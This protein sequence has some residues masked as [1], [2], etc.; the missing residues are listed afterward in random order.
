MQ[1]NSDMQFNSA[2]YFVIPGLSVDKKRDD[3]ESEMISLT[4][5]HGLILHPVIENGIATSTVTNGNSLIDLVY[6]SSSLTV[7]TGR[8]YELSL[9]DHFPISLC[10]KSRAPNFSITETLDA[11][12]FELKYFTVDPSKF[13]TF[14]FTQDLLDSASDTYSGSINEADNAILSNLLELANDRKPERS[15]ISKIDL[16]IAET[17]RQIRRAKNK[18]LKSGKFP[19]ENRV[20]QSFQQRLQKLIHEKDTLMKEKVRSKFNKARLDKNAKRTW[21][22]AFES[23]DLKKAKNSGKLLSRQVGESFFIN[24]YSHSFAPRQILSITAACTFLDSSNISNFQLNFQS[25]NVDS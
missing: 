23:L 25:L 11:A 1:F 19:L 24:L 10:L 6:A 5:A 16:R 18:L 22:A 15:K 3:E 8:I 14:E 20:F 17:R 4:A 21:E 12:E 2:E 9:S 7:K 13:D